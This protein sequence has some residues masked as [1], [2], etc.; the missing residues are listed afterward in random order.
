MVNKVILLGNVGGEPETKVLDSGV[1]MT[2]LSLA[3][4]K[5]WKTDGEPREETQWHTIIMWRG[6]S[7]VTEKYVKKGSKIYI[8]GE[9]THRNYQGDDGVKKYFTEVVASE[10]KMLD[11][12]KTNDSETD[13]N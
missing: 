2:K 4:T 7:K 6:L 3:T 13:K 9:L 8:E 11:G 10:M 5:R 12:K 1:Q